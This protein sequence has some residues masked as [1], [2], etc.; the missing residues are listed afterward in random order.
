MVFA[1][2]RKGEKMPRYIDADALIERLGINQDCTECSY[3]TRKYYCSWNPDPGEICIAISEQPTVTINDL[4]EEIKVTNCNY[5]QFADVSK[6]GDLISR[7]D[8]LSCFHDWI[9]KHGDVHTADEMPEYQRIEQ[10]PSAQPE[11]KRGKWIDYTEDGFV[12]CPYCRSATNCESN[13]DELHYCFS[14]GAEL[15]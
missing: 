7:Q 10:L 11:R 14:C 2:L 15:R 8:A 4:T 6:K 9:D 12:E 1:V 3:C 13:K 5:N